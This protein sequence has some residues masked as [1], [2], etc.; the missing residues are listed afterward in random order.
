MTK[1]FGF[2]FSSFII[3]HSSLLFGLLMQGT[4]VILRAEFR[5][6]HAA[7]LFALVFRRRVIPHFADGTL[8]CNNVSHDVF[9]KLKRV[10]FEF[11]CACRYLALQAFNIIQ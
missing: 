4:L 9:L 3:H 10:L 8:E 11:V 2:P 6:F 5:V 7:R 1:E